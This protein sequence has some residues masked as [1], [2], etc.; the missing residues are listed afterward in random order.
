MYLDTEGFRAKIFRRPYVQEFLLAVS[1][2]FEVVLFTG[3]A[4]I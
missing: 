2:A 1:S 3:G 4:I